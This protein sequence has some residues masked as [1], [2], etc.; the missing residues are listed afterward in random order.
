MQN[1]NFKDLFSTQAVDYARFRPTYPQELFSFLS[2]LTKNK[3]SAWDCGTGN[4][5][6]A[7]ELA[8][9][10]NHVVATDP[11]SKQIQSAMLDPRITYMTASAEDFY[12]PEKEYDEKFDLITV[13]QAFHWFNH[14]KFAYVVKHVAAKDC[15][16]VVWSY[17]NAFV[18]PEVDSAVH[19][20]YEDI[21]HDYW[22]PERKLVEEGYKS[23]T[24]PFEEVPAPVITMK[25]EW[26]CEHFIGYLSTWSALQKYIARNG[27]NPLVEEAE[28][29]KTAWGNQ[30]NRTVS[31]PLSI[32]IWKIT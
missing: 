2:N 31:W 17:A 3:N 12:S 19:H 14:A 8:K 13:A 7:L 4:G 5:Q 28:K 30:E 10:F 22:D 25:A 21:L 32:R 15:H 18:S 27:K 11:S 20:L 23:I 24:M 6:A 26:S 9:F 1:S 29:I 16:L